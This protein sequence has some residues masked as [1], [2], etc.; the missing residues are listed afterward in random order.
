MNEQ[1]ARLEL[2]IPVTEKGFAIGILA[3]NCTISKQRLKQAMMKGAVWQ[4]HGGKTQRIRRAKKELPVG[5][6]LHLYYDE[7]ILSAKPPKPQLI[8]DEGSYSVWYKPYGML[9]QGSKWGDHCTINRWA[10]QELKP[11]RP[12]FIVHRLDR[13]ASGLIIIA[14][15]KKSAAALSALFQQR[16]I[17]KR[18]RV[19]V[20]GPFPEQPAT[21]TINSPIDGREACS[22]VQHIKHHEELD[23]SL[24][25]VSI[26]TGRKHQIRKHL[27]EAGFAVVG[28]RLYG[29]AKDKEDLQL[30]A[31]L[32]KFI[33]PASKT[34][35]R[36][37]LADALIPG[38]H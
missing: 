38:F 6:A 21:Q 2:H 31:Y 13:A 27:A 29:D 7:R 24:L 5:D 32:L 12:S 4:T 35:K 26:E 15:Q 33:S 1:S 11:Q 30:C 19:I 34:E 23:R 16:D 36:Y 8:C 14:H 3:D 37:V 28:D 18:Y 22:H 20:H 25:D 9:S 17:E 10:E